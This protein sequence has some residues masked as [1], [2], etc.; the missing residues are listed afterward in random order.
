MF[1]IVLLNA[2]QR[3]PRDVYNIPAP[4]EGPNGAVNLPNNLPAPQGV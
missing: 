3:D 1:H 2:I 4:I